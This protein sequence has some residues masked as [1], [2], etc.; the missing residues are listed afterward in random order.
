METFHTILATFCTSKIVSLS[1]KKYFF[2]LIFTWKKQIWIYAIYKC[3]NGFFCTAS[4]LRN[5]FRVRAQSKERSF[6]VSKERI[7][8]SK[9]KWTSNRSSRTCEI[10]ILE[11]L[12]GQA[13]ESVVLEDWS[14]ALQEREE[15]FMFSFVH[16]EDLRNIITSRCPMTSVFVSGLM[17]VHI[18]LLKYIFQTNLR[19]W[20]HS[21]EAHIRKC[22]LWI[23]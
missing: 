2:K 14:F 23:E 20:K 1:P 21:K 6:K 8:D 17:D 19:T 12:K 10:T 13:R 18:V 16:R 9:A 11:E 3:R 7:L 15:Y 4:H 22:G 5:E